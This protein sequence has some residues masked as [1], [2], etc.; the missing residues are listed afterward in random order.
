[1]FATIIA[2][3]AIAFIF[4]IYADKIKANPEGISQYQ[5]RFFIWVALSEAFP[6]LLVVLDDESG[7]S[8]R[9]WGTYDSCTNYYHIY[10]V[11][12]LFHLPANNG[13]CK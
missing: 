9:S 4:K 8:R 13:R 7:K 11:F 3:L 1:M 6:I 5:T 12:S 10:G 2:V